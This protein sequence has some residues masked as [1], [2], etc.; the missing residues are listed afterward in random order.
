MKA[1]RR[2]VAAR[3]LTAIAAG[4]MFDAGARGGLWRN[5]TGVLDTL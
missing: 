4:K 3:P 5:V 2:I 1:A